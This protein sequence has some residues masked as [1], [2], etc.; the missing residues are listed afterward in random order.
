MIRHPTKGIVIKMKEDIIEMLHYGQPIEVQKKG[1]E[2][3]MGME[4]L[5]FLLEK[6]ELPEYSDNCA[7]VFTSL[8][9]VRCRKYFDE[10]FAWIEDINAPD[11]IRIIDYLSA[12][13]CETVYDSFKNATSACLKRVNSANAQ[14]L[15]MIL[16]ANRELYN[17]FLRRDRDLLKQLTCI[18]NDLSF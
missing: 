4:E 2:L 14:T 17:E 16:R 6:A 11:A 9:Y 13:P 7:T 15:K 12:A 5:F 8:D 3:A 10:L 18:T 1:I